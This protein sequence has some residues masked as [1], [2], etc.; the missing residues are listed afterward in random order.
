MQNNGTPFSE[1][2]NSLCSVLLLSSVSDV[3][4]RLFSLRAKSSVFNLH[5]FLSLFQPH[6]LCY[7]IPVLKLFFLSAEKDRDLE[8]LVLLCISQQSNKQQPENH[9]NRMVPLLKTGDTIHRFRHS[10]EGPAAVPLLSTGSSV[11]ASQP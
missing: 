6:Q 8:F 1:A 3:V 11:V 7:C 10:H 4:G 5:P 2:Y 9:R